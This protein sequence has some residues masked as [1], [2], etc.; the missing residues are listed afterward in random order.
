MISNSLIY[1]N[2][3]LVGNPKEMVELLEESYRI[4]GSAEVRIDSVGGLVD[5]TE[6]K[7]KL[8]MMKLQGKYFKS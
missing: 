4:K 8:E 2:G 6:E 5:N 1:I 3:K 7:L